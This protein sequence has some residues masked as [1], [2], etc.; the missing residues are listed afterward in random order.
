V[1]SIIYIYVIKRGLMWRDA[2]KG[3]GSHKTVYNRFI[4][5]SR[6]G[7]FNRILAEL[8]DKAGEPDAIIIDA[9]LLKA[10]RAAASPLKGVLYPDVSDAPRAD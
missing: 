1:S 8:A 10:H 2:P 4:H 7:V 9:T 3:Y 6:L 5:W